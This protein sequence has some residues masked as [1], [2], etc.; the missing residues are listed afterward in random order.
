MYSYLKHLLGGLFLLLVGCSESRSYRTTSISPPDQETLQ[1]IRATHQALGAGDAP[2]FAV[3]EQAM[4]GFDSIPNL[5]HRDV[6]A[7]ADFSLPA[8]EK[9]FFVIDLVK[10][11]V[12]Y[13]CHV[14]HGKNSGGNMATD[15]SNVPE[16]RK[17]CLGFFVTAETYSGNH[18]YSLR[19]DGIEQ[20]INHNAR[21]R[22]IVIHPASYATQAF[23]RKNGRLGRSWGCPAL[24][25][26]LS[27]GII[28]TIANGRCLFIYA[29]D[30]GYRKRSKYVVGE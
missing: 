9:R 28:N 8:T 25:P 15:F 4:L 13:H 11:Q 27:K 14:T 1:A 20:D 30:E 12:L 6:I 21:K 16:S 19:I 23:V 10:P 5:P 3:F 7:I 22:A 18:G 29:D 26:H 17:S 2:S 24:P